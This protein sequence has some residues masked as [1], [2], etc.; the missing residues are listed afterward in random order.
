MIFTVVFAL[1]AAISNVVSLLAQHLASLAAP[2]RE[3]GWRLAL[4][5][6]RNPLWLLGGAAVGSYVLQALAL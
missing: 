2:R 5:L 3:Q 4:Y 6:A 1:A